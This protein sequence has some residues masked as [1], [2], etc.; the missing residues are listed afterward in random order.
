MD[1]DIKTELGLLIIISSLT[2]ENGYCFASNEY[3]ANQ[4]EI[5]TTTVSRRIKKLIDKGYLKAK[6]ERRG[7]QVINRELRIAK[8]LTDRWQKRQPT[9]SKTAKDNSTSINTIDIKKQLR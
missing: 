4:F 9:V 5:D 7:S 3:L 2:A 8:T 1:K 6:Y